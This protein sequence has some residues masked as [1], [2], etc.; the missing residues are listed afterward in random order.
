MDTF[1][2]PKSIVVF[3]VSESEKNLGRIII[4]NLYNFNYKGKIYAIGSSGGYI[5]EKKI[6]SSLNEI[7]DAID[8]S[9]LLVPAIFVPP[10]LEEC[11]KKGIKRVIIESGGFSEFSE[12]RK[13][14]EEKIKNIA[15]TYN[16]KVIG[17]NCFGVINLKKGVILPFFILSPEYMKSGGISIISQSGGI[18]YD[19]CMISSCEN[20]GLCKVISI[21]NKLLINENTC[22]EYLVNDEDT[23]VIGLY[24]EDFSDGKT[25]M[26]IVASTE[27]PVVLLKGN[28]TKLSH[29]I[30]KFHTSALAGDDEVAFAAMSQV[31]VIVVDS[32]QDFIDSL[33]ALSLNSMKG[34]KVGVISRSGGHSVLAADAVEKYHLTLAK[35]SESF[36][37][38]VKEKKLNVIRA[39]NPLDVGDVYDLDLYLEILEKALMEEDVDGIVFVITYSSE[40]DGL[41]VKRFIE[42]AGRLSQ[43]FNKPIALSVITNREEWFATRNSGSLPVFFDCDRAVWA[44]EKSYRHFTEKKKRGL[45]RSLYDASFEKTLRHFPSNI[46]TLPL[47]QTFNLLK[48]YN[49]PLAEF[50][51]TEDKEELPNLAKSIGYPVVLKNASPEMIHKTEAGGVI[52]NIENEELLRDAINRM[53]ATE[54]LIQKMFPSGFEIL[55]GIKFNRDFGHV[56]VVGFGGIYTEIIKDISMRIMPVNYHM[57]G[58]MIEELKG[59]AILKGYR[60]LPHADIDAIKK[61]IVNLSNFVNL[62]NEIYALDL[63]PVI[64]FEKDC[65]AVIVDA[66]MSLIQ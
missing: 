12:E 36:F 30:A 55:I 52:L 20:M 26:N 2:N 21:G 45:F 66:R 14:L 27:K 62:H 22:L 17:P 51:F 53:N 56:I 63:N 33:K 38:S 1:F 15:F 46:K 28:R 7:E 25:F 43:M 57:A 44:L 10:I 39:T 8:L 16:I 58:E 49:L 3:G 34:K 64:V 60:G 42:H 19:T 13:G 29:E 47:S 32:F 61:I 18:F 4:E 65:G 54:Y 37:S 11:G 31:G 59:S 40:S 41:K 48:K 5:K 9:V 35:Y 6:F 24:L 23:H 50:R